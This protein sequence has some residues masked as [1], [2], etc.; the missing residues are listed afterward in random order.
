MNPVPQHAPEFR[1]IGSMGVQ[2]ENLLSS[3]ALRTGLFA[4][5]TRT[6]RRLRRV[7]WRILLG[8][9]SGR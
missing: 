4:G 9:S 2:W 3:E 7:D 6:I 8:F 5:L 1:T